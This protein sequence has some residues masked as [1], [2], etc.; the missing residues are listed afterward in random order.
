MYY[1]HIF[2]GSRLFVFRKTVSDLIS[3]S[4]L[5]SL[6]PFTSYVFPNI[7]VIIYKPSLHFRSVTAGS[8]VFQHS[9][10]QNG[11]K[12]EGNFS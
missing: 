10:A 7:P 1:Q 3:T 5:T 6:K 4:C 9:A 11:K 2:G 12:I 8:L